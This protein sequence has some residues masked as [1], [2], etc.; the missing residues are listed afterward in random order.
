MSR[1]FYC[2]NQVNTQQLHYVL[3]L[4]AGITRV[5]KAAAVL[6]SPRIKNGVAVCWYT[7]NI[8]HTFSLPPIN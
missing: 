6:Q 7:M 3:A 8:A 5:H 1:D 4:P 2:K